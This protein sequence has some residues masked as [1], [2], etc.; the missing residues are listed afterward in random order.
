MVTVALLL[1]LVTLWA[2]VGWIWA[3]LWI[4]RYTW[5]IG[6][7]EEAIKEE[8]FNHDEKVVVRNVGILTWRV[9]LSN[10]IASKKDRVKDIKVFACIATLSFFMAIGAAAIAFLIMGE[11]LYWDRMPL[12]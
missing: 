5:A 4:R 8:C 10:L 12:W 6:I 2:I 1:P 11:R 9:K 3:R 7:L